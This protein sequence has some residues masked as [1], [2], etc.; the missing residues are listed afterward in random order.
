MNCK[1][2][3]SGTKSSGFGKEEWM[4]L[5]NGA[6]LQTNCDKEG[7]NIKSHYNLRLRIGIENN[8]EDDCKTCDSVIGFGIQIETPLDGS[9]KWSSGNVQFYPKDERHTFQT[10]GY[11]FVQ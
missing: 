11:I 9:W 7:F 1:Y 8:N 6:K 5:I 4:S 3:H 10:F 2:L